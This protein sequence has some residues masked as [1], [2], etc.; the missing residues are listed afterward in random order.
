MANDR[1]MLHPNTNSVYKIESV[2][3]YDPLFTKDYAKLVSSW[4]ANTV[5]E[6]G[7]FN[8]IVTPQNYQSRVA[9]FLNVKYL[10]SINEISD[11]RF[12]KVFEQGETKVYENKKVLPRAFFAKEIVKVA[13]AN[14]ELQY[15]LSSNVDL[16]S[17]AVSSQ[18]S[19]QVQD[20]NSSVNFEN[21]QDQKFTLSVYTDKDSPLI[22][23]N[24]FYPG[25]QAFI[26]GNKTNIYKV[27]FMFQSI[28]IPQGNHKIEFKFRPQSFYNGIYVSVI[29]LVVTIFI[30]I[31]LWHRKYQ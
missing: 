20:N 3:G 18:L 14:D 27:N 19:Y 1:R 15:I 24:P 2:N 21:Y 10:L 13:S 17:S 6:A 31:I 25:W 30:S 9:D 7:S 4:N 12:V 23:S 5:S 28:I 16:E 8:R 29:G 22:V 11:A 26:D